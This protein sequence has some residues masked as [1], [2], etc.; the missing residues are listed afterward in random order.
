MEHHL[1]LVV[2]DGLLA[3]CHLAPGTRVPGA[4][5]AGE[6]SAAIQTSQEVTLICQAESVPDGV[7]VETGWRAIKVEGVLDFSMT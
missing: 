2:L 5:L 7:L 4:V 6:F 1:A 3:V